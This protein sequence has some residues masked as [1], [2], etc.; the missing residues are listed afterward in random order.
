[1]NILDYK[2]AEENSKAWNI[3]NLIKN[4]NNEEELRNPTSDSFE[5]SACAKFELRDG[6]L[7]C[8]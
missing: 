1:M 5:I 4:V 7:I 2:E 6:L 3:D 8:Q